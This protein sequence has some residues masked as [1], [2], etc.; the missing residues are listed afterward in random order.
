[1]KM[2]PVLRTRIRRRDWR[3]FMSVKDDVVKN[4]G[5]RS[6]ATGPVAASVIEN[7][8]GGAGT[9]GK[10][11]KVKDRAIANAARPIAPKVD[12]KTLRATM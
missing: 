7:P 2:S 1:M 12:K 9:D 3:K 8:G 5:S 10:L 11:A 4:S 6:L